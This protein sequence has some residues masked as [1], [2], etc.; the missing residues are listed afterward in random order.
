MSVQ[1]RSIK[2]YQVELTADR[3]LWISDEPKGVGDDAGPN[4]Y[5]LLLGALG[6]CKVITV[7]MYARRKG[8]PLEAVEVSLSTYKI[9]AKDCENCES[10]PNAKIDVIE[11][12]IGFKGA[13][14][15]EQIQR[16]V[17]ISEHCPVHRTLV[18]ET[19]I[20]TRL[21]NNLERPDI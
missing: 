17:E 2:N 7:Q 5:E 15:S 21:V 4:P 1:A 3:H 9:H 20:R 18:S 13:L 19:Q 6:S 10:D 8:W 12:E 14:T 16:L 11:C